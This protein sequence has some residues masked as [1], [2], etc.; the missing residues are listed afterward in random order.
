MTETPA[1][2]DA[3][4]AADEAV[5]APTPEAEAEPEFVPNRS[6]RRGGAKKTNQNS[7]IP[8]QMHNS[9]VVGKRSFTNRRSG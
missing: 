5:E 7:S 2:K 3:N 8:G 4:D 9:N 6:D 1:P